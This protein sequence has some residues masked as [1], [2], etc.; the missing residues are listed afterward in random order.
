VRVNEFEQRVLDVVRDL[1]PAQVVSYGWVASECGR[2]RAARAVGAVLGG[3]ADD[4]VPWWRVVQS[5]G[6]IVSPR[7]DVQRAR[8]VADGV[9]VRGDRVV[10]PPVQRP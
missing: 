2:P 6:R 5:N 3:L 7:P 10:E 9:V 1:Q 4:S 8:L